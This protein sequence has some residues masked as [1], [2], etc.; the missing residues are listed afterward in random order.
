MEE[1]KNMMSGGGKMFHQYWHMVLAIVAKIFWVA[2]VVFVVAAWMSVMRND[3][4][5]GYG[6]Q[7]WIWNT[8]MFGVLA[9]Y[10]RGH[11]KCTC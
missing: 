8:L 9:L 6:A 5:W 7:W 3:L 4:V 11:G 1:Q 10:G 2:A